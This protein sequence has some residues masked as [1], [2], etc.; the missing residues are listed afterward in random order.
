MRLSKQLQNVHSLSTDN[1]TLRD[2]GDRAQAMERLLTEAAELFRT[3]EQS[4]RVRG[5]E[6][7][8]KAER[9]AD[10]A[11]RIEHELNRS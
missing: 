7:L 4:H 6:H 9:N 10:I 5:P 1:E 2:L 11:S 3:Y 8:A